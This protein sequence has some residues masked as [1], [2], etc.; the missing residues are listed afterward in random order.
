MHRMAKG[1]YANY[2]TDNQGRD[3]YISYD[4]GG[5]WPNVTVFSFAKKYEPNTTFYSNVRHR[6]LSTSKKAP[7]FRY[8]SDGTGRDSYV[9]YNSGGLFYDRKP[10]YKYKL[11]D[12]LR[13]SDVN[14]HTSKIPIFFTREE[15][16]KSRIAR[17]KEIETNNRLC[18]S[19]RIKNSNV[20]HTFYGFSS[21]IINCEN[22]KNCGKRNIFMS[23]L[24]T[25]EFKNTRIQSCKHKINKIYCGFNKGNDENI[26]DKR[27]N[28]RCIKPKFKRIF[29]YKG[30]YSNK[31]N[32]IYKLKTRNY[33][34]IKSLKNTKFTSVGDYNKNGKLYTV[35]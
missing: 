25:T 6:P 2:I 16:I 7:N 24:T 19:K 17:Q 15:V 5:F 22:E 1:N 10:L 33:T 34:G 14:Q 28:F 20:L 31:P 18:Y 32:M 13:K 3:K 29:N 27:E 26:E 8:Y 23:N 9:Y 30:P 11:I 21:N 4:N 35:Y 12:F